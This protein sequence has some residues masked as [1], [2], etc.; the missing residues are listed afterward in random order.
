MKSTAEIV[1][2][3]M[4]D[5]TLFEHL[6]KWELREHAHDILS[7]SWS[8]ALNNR[9]KARFILSCSFDLKVILWDL[10]KENTPLM[11][12]FEHPEVPSQVCFNPYFTE[13]FVSVS[14]D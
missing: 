9:G 10:D 13:T 8:E 1:K 12:I 3:P 11:D 5:L 14:L 6:P 4:S 7:L 2:Q